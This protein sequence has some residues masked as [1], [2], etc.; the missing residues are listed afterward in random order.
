[1]QDIYPATP[2]QQGLIFHGLLLPGQGVYLNQLRFTLAGAL[3]RVALR[4]AWEAAVA[5]HDVLRTSF[6]WRHGG[7]ALQVVHR[8]A[9]LAYTEH[10]WSARST[11]DYAAA[12]SEWRTA[13]LACDF[14]LAMAL[15]CG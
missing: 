2:L 13:D 5:R 12:L 9:R 7:E 11:D 8:Q 6:E 14:D 15:R 3:D 10:A 1:M 4:G